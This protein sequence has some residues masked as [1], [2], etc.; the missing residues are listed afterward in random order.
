MK[1]TV[2]VYDVI[3]IARDGKS[4]HLKRSKKKIYHFFS[5]DNFFS[6]SEATRCLRPIIIIIIACIFISVDYRVHSRH[7][8]MMIIWFFFFFFFASHSSLLLLR[9]VVLLRNALFFSVGNVCPVY[10]HYWSIHE[11]TFI[12]A[13]AFIDLIRSRKI[14]LV[15]LT[16]WKKRRRKKCSKMHA[17]ALGPDFPNGPG[18][19]V[20]RQKVSSALNSSSFFFARRFPSVCSDFEI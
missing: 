8:L 13:A 16:H 17:S 10:R 3:R 19:T 18:H 12:H 6:P 1:F 5:I 2:D 11:T 4:Q 9:L 14:Q 7:V 15:F 20:D